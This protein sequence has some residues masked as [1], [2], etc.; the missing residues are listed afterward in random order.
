MPDE[1]D[2]L[3]DAF[4]AKLTELGYAPNPGASPELLDRLETENGW[5]FP[6]AVRRYL[7]K[8][9]GCSRGFSRGGGDGLWDFYPIEDWLCLPCGGSESRTQEWIARRG[10]SDHGCVCFADALILA[11]VWGICLN[12]DLPLWGRVVLC[13]DFDPQTYFA[14]L[15]EADSF[16]SFMSAFMKAPDDVFPNSYGLF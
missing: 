15:P 6:D 11:P 14:R 10:W 5:K 1:L 16:E 9:N 3:I 8:A 2:S 4:V 12:S 7:L 13:D